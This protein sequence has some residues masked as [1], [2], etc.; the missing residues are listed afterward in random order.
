MEKLREWKCSGT[1]PSG[2]EAMEAIEANGHRRKSEKGRVQGNTRIIVMVNG[3]VNP[4]T[5]G[6]PLLA[7]GTLVDRNRKSSR[8]VGGSG[9]S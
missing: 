6:S 7:R 9:R 4:N 1:A 5:R 3:L 8:L 2:G